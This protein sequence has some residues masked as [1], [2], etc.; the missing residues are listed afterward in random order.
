MGSRSGILRAVSLGSSPSS[1]ARARASIR[2]FCWGAERVAV[3]LVAH[4]VPE[5]VANERRRRARANRDQR[6][7]PS[8]EKL[9]LLGWNIFVTNVTSRVWP[10][11]AIQPI[12]RVRWRIEIIFKAWKSHLGLR[13]LNCRTADLLR[14]SAMT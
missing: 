3:R 14:L 1:W 8:K 2:G 12:Y 11:R 9:Y 10:L 7:I 5:A 13:Q 6:C 4:P